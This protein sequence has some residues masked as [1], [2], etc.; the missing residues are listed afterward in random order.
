MRGLGGDGMDKKPHTALVSSGKHVQEVESKSG[1]HLPVRGRSGDLSPSAIGVQVDQ[2]EGSETRSPRQRHE[3]TGGGS[4]EGSAAWKTGGMGHQGTGPVLTGA[5]CRGEG[6]NGEKME[7]ENRW[8]EHGHRLR[9]MAPGDAKQV[10]KD[11][12]P[13]GAYKKRGTPRSKNER[14]NYRG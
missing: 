10:E 3:D 8:T 11:V 5:V 12:T 7:G 1:R 13:Q 4:H 14:T 9:K 6:D 2:Q